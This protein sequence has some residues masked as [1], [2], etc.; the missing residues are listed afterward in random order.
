MQALRYIAEMGAEGRISLP[1]IKLR[2]GTAVEIIVLVREPEEDVSDLL[3]AS[4]SS[5]SFWD[6][7]IDDEVWNDA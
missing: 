1:P 4:T 6:N 7:P 2:E 3:A 5:L